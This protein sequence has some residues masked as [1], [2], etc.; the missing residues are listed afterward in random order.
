MSD[1]TPISGRGGRKTPR[2]PCRAENDNKP[3]PESAIEPTVLPANDNEA[4]TAIQTVITHDYV[5]TAPTSANDND[6][7][8]T[9]DLPRPLPVLPREAAIVRKLLGDRFRQ[10]LLEEEKG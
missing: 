2:L 6:I 4:V 1:R 10:I 3:A 5:V 7:L 8:V 9:D